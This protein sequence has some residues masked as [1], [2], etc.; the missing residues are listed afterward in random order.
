MVRASSLLV[1]SGATHEVRSVSSEEELPTDCRRVQ[2]QLAAGETSAWM[3]SDGIVYVVV[4]AAK[5]E[6]KQKLQ[7]LLPL[8][9]YIQDCDLALTWSRDNCVLRSPSGACFEMEQS[10]L[11]ERLNAQITSTKRKRNGKDM[12]KKRELKGDRHM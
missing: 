12:G 10:R 7:P 8:G 1:D 3:S 5:D 4:P 2:L 11:S 9:A 6:P